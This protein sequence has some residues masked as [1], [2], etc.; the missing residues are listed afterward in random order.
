MFSRW[1]ENDIECSL[2][3]KLQ[4]CNGAD[5]SVI[6]LE[7]IPMPGYQRQGH[8]SAEFIKEFRRRALAREQQWVRKIKG[9]HARILNIVQDPPVQ[10]TQKR[11]E[12]R[13]M[14]KENLTSPKA[15]KAKPSVI[16]PKTPH[17]WITIDDDK[18]IL[19]AT[20]PGDFIRIRRSLSQLIKD[21]TSGKDPLER[22]SE[23]SK[24]YRR[25]VILF[26]MDQL[27]QKEIRFEQS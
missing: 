4:G 6:P 5:I 14:A 12:R 19:D 10:R 18:M 8:H 11:R 13:A 7:V 25:E 22:I 9:S 3:R 20:T 23:W 26:L 15:P 16:K 27:E 21:Q 17:K 2:Q 1:K 24:Q